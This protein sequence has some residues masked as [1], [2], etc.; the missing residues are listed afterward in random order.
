MWLICLLV[1]LL[2]ERCLPC[3][4]S[5][6]LLICESDLHTEGE[7]LIIEQKKIQEVTKLFSI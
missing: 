3:S 5:K 7:P 1:L 2:K 4:G 6:H